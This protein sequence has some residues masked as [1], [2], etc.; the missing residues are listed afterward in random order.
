MTEP[1]RLADGV[2]YGGP[3][4]TGLGGD[5][6]DRQIATVVALDL[7]GNKAV[8]AWLD[9]AG[10]CEGALFRPVVKGGRLG[11]SRLTAKSVC[12]L[13]KAYVD[14]LGLNAGAELF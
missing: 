5:P 7:A 8:K 11:A 14:R 12:D 9:A 10:I 3:A 13:V 2:L 1:P 6:V 4:N